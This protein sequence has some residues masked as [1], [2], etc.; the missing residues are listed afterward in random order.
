MTNELI[1]KSNE[2]IQKSVGEM[3]EQLRVIRHTAAGSR[4]RNVRE[5]RSVRREIARGLTELRARTLATGKTELAG[6]SK[7]A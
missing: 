5:A 7:K 2:E 3:R 6:E 4:S 1:K